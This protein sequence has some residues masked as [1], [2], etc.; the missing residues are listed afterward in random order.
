MFYSRFSMAVCVSLGASLTASVILAETPEVNAAQT[1]NLAKT[2]T[3]PESSSTSL[4]T[5]P[6]AQD[7]LSQLLVQPAIE[8]TQNI[9]L[10]IAPPN[11]EVKPTF[12]TRVANRVFFWR[13]PKNKYTAPVEPTIIV[14]V[15]GAP[16]VLETNLKETLQQVT[17]IEFEDFQT[18]IPRLRSMA[19]S[20]AQAVGYYK[21]TFIFSKKSKNRLKVDV[22]TGAPVKI[23]SQKIIITGEGETDSVFIQL[24]QQPDL[25]VGDTLNHGAYEQ[26]KAKI[27]GVARDRGYFNGQYLKRDVQVDWPTQTADIELSYATGERYVFGDV[28]YKNS[29]PNKGLRLK[30]SVLAALQP[31]KAGEPYDA[32]SLAKL[33]R[34]LQDTRYFNNIQVDAPTPD[35]LPDIVSDLK[36]RCR[37]QIKWMLSVLRPSLLK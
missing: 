5:N 11:I 1:L 31:F 3:N 17:V 26:T 19:V 12:L 29:N 30:P 27:V 13:T 28:T 21:A 18:D 25:N 14:E 37:N 10:P 33:S 6:I 7:N 20:A 24:Q 32:A 23:A 35:P 22:V 34:N 9:P 16:A 4:G 36:N 15:N 2:S 8:D